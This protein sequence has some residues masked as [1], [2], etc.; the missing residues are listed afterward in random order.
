MQPVIPELIPQFSIP[1]GKAPNWLLFCIS[2]C[3]ILS[4]YS[5]L[6]ISSGSSLP[7]ALNLNFDEMSRPFIIPLFPTQSVRLVWASILTSHSILHTARYSTCACKAQQKFNSSVNFPLH[8]N[9]QVTFS[10]LL[11]HVFFAIEVHS[12]G[13]NF[14]F[15]IFKICFILI[16][17][18]RLGKSWRRGLCLLLQ[19]EPP[20]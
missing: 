1:M 7:A 11:Q 6:K 2:S 3:L 4:C 14:I 5:Q 19:F 20:H 8:W 13:Q 9:L 15:C 17:S 12:W 18:T 10:E 16:I